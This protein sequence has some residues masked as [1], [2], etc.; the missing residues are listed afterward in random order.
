MVGSPS[1]NV[2]VAAPQITQINYYI[3][4]IATTSDTINKSG[5]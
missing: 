1:E 3:M 4:R 2:F 5:Y